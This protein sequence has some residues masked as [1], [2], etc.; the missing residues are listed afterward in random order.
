[1]D[2]F[3]VG[4]CFYS[5]GQRVAVEAGLGPAL[6]HTSHS[7]K[8]GQQ[9]FWF[10]SVAEFEK[11]RQDIF[12][13]RNAFHRPVPVVE[14]LDEQPPEPKTAPPVAAPSLQAVASFET[15]KAAMNPA[16]APPAPLPPPP[17]LPGTAPTLPTVAD[18][19]EAEAIFKFH[20]GRKIRIKEFAAELNCS[21]EYLE[22]IIKND[23]RYAP[24]VGGWVRL[25]G[26]PE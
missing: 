11:Y 8:Y 14:M 7:E 3:R 17:P 25:A 16:F 12:E 10:K 23:P 18:P 4:L 19:L 22:P 1:M 15:A 20:A 2:R 21:P 13:A 26:Q 6:G 5:A 9:V 24:I